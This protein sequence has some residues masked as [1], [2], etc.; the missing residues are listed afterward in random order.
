MKRTLS[1]ILLLSMLVPLVSCSATGSGETLVQTT[2]AESPEVLTGEEE[3]KEK[4]VV[5]DDLDLGGRTITLG[6]VDNDSH[7][8]EAYGELAGDVV[9]EA[10]YYRNLNAEEKL[11]FTLKPLATATATLDGANLFVSTALA[12]DHVWDINEGMQS[13]VS[14]R[15]LEGVFAN[16]IDIPYLTLEKPW[17]KKD[18]IEEFAIGTG[19]L[20]FLFGDLNI[21]MFKAAG[22]M[23]FNKRLMEDA[24]MKPDAFYDLIR[25]GKWTYD[26]LYEMSQAAYVDV[27]G[28]GNAD[29][30][31]RYGILMT[32]VSSV[33]LFFY[34]AAG[35]V[36]TRDKDGIP[37][38]TVNNEHTVAWCDKIYKLY[39]ENK[40]AKVGSDADRSKD[41]D[42][43]FTNSEALF[44]AW[45]MNLAA[46]GYLS[47]MED[48]YGLAPFPKLNDVQDRYYTM[49]HNSA[50]LW[51][52]PITAGRELLDIVGAVL[53]ELAYQAH[54]RV[55]PA[56]YEVALKAKYAR[57]S[58]DAEMID[59][60]WNS[61]RTDFGYCFAAAVVNLGTLRTFVSDKS[62]DW[63]SFY[64]KNQPAAQKGLDD[65]I[66][67]YLELGN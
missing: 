3:T 11:N 23:Y 34:A 47:E 50:S 9:S 53:E 45:M 38:L 6:Y 59:L 60:I 5:P 62:T 16:L 57:A 26:R 21:A 15:M 30:G 52:V 35:R 33:E 24:F 1:L 41:F 36:T 63:A 13:Y 14:K 64:A 55:I 22:T 51:C 61:V 8:T 29:S 7:R 54:I 42:L 18:Y 19:K 37:Q 48:D 65:L 49:V 32:N 12:G 20:Y 56:F 40:G 31:D 44:Y 27:N 10:V 4:S 39:Y 17:W 46:N 43:I 25:E 28:N 2:A 66:S 58:A 67:H